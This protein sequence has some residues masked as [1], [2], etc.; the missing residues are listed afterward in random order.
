VD[1]VYSMRKY[2]LIAAIAGFGLLGLDLLLRGR[3]NLSLWAWL[4]GA[5]LTSGGAALFLA[6]R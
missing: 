6:S 4:P 2:G 3:V 1:Y 5:V